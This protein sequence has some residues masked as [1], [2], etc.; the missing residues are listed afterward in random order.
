MFI[1]ISIKSRGCINVTATT[2]GSYGETAVRQFGPSYKSTE[3][4]LR[5]A[6]QL[7]Q[8]GMKDIELYNVNTKHRY[9]FKG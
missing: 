6:E 3:A 8:Q 7:K 2:M 1:D 4:A 9:H 5:K